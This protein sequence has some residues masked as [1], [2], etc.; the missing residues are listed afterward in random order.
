MKMKCET[1]QIMRMYVSTYILLQKLQALLFHLYATAAGVMVGGN[2]G[3]C[4]FR[5]AL[6]P[7]FG[8]RENWC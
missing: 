6:I 5:P 4:R 3:M 8:K 2:G 7:M 1:Q